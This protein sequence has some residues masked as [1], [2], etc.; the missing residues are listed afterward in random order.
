MAR[1]TAK[2]R[3]SLPKFDG[4]PERLVLTAR[5][6]AQLLSRFSSKAEADAW[7]KAQAEPQDPPDA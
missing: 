2:A 5:L 3:K 4:K 7:L 1:L 6:K